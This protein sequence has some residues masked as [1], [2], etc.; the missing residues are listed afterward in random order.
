MNAPT[1][2]VQLPTSFKLLKGVQAHFAL[3]R[4]GPRKRGFHPSEMPYLCPVKFAIYD[5]ALDDFASP[6]PVVLQ[7]A[8]ATVRKILDTI[9]DVSPGKLP[10]KLIPDFHVGDAIHAGVQYWLGVRG[11]L[12][13]KWECPWC[14]AVSVDG[15]MPRRLVSDIN[16]DQMY[17]AA[18]C[19]RCNGQNLREKTIKWRYV[20]PWS[21]N[22][23][24]GLEGNCDGIL[25]VKYQGRTI[26]AVLEIKSIN[27]NGYREKYNGP[28]PQEGHIKQASQYVWALSQEHGWLA[29]LQHI[30]FI[31]VNK[32]AVRDWK[33]FLVQS[34][35]L[36]MTE[37][38]AK[39]R[40]V[41][42]AREQRTLPLAARSCPDITCKSARECPV[43]VECFGEEPPV[44]IFAADFDPSTLRRQPGGN[45]GA[46]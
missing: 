8:F 10:S 26:V 12:W 1:Q 46:E 21:G 37:L 9:H 24:W 41:I 4:R 7:R 17:D 3:Q 31:Y 32:N 29:E 6:D 35:P 14:H 23:E 45:D 19:A 27:E 40:A 5:N 20:E 25:V 38:Q 22:K 33:E 30:Y 43:V 44:N 34:D 2:V 18:P 15:F 16:D 42:E 39:M 11:L 13:G 28:L 36:I